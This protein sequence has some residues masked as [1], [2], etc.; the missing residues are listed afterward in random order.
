VELIPVQVPESLPEQS[1][2]LTPPVV[3]SER[4]DAAPPNGM[5]H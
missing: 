3:A 1:V 4:L 5:V 2:A